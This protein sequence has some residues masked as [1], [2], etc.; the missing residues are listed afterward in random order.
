V[1]TQEWTALQ[2]AAAVK[3]PPGGFAPVDSLAYA[4]NS[5]SLR[6]AFDMHFNRFPGFEA[7]TEALEAWR[8]RYATLVGIAKSVLGPE[9]HC[10]DV[11]PDLF[12]AFSDCYKSDNG[13]RPRFWMTVAEVEA[14]FA[15]RDAA[16]AR[17]AAAPARPRNCEECKA[18]GRAC[19]FDGNRCGVLS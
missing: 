6:T 17:E 14:W 18:S 9:A 15:R 19:D 8:E 3:A 11:D 16:E 1:N 13:I 4:S 12:S 10:N 7:P 5:D 2:Q